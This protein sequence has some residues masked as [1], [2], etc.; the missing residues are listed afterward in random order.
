V[1]DN[2]GDIVVE[3]AGEGIDTIFSSVSLS[4]N[5]PGRFAVENL[6][7][8]GGA[9]TGIGNSLNNV[10]NGNGLNNFLSGL[11]GNDTINGFAGNDFMIGGAGRDIMA[12]GFGNDTFDYNV[13]TDSLANASRDIIR[14][15]D[16]VG[17]DTIDLSGVSAGVLAFRGILPFNGA[18]QVRINDIVGPDVFVEVNLGG[19]LAPEMQIHLTNTTAASMNAADFVL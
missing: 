8:F 4:L 5:V 6:S 16:D 9:I 18:G 1:V 12:G 2:F 15:F 19:T 11:G 7:L 17:N 10:I 3:G 13:F 14:D